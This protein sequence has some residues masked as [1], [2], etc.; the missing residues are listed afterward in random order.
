[1]RLRAHSWYPSLRSAAWIVALVAGAGSLGLLLRAGRNTPPLLLVLLAVW[2]ASPFLVAAM[3][4][5]VL[6]RCSNASR[7]F[8]YSATALIALASLIAYG[9]DAFRPRKAQA[10]FVF[11]ATP[12]VSWLT[13]A[14]VVL[15][16][17]RRRLK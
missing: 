9:Y 6:K 10:G 7:T 13:L 16:A 5:K 2:V 17:G 12:L 1:M 11:V 15:L 8:L 4:R 3:P 14:T